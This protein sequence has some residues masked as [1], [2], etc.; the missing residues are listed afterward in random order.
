MLV[1]T[2]RT[3]ESVMLE[4]SFVKVLGINYET[5]EVR[6]GFSFPSEVTILREK[7]YHASKNEESNERFVDKLIS[8]LAG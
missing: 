4:D 8:K 2:C 5:G 1:L 6:L 3:H 7:L